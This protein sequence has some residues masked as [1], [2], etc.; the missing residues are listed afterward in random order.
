M[1]NLLVALTASLFS[2]FAAACIATPNEAG[3]VEPDQEM[4]EESSQESVQCPPAGLC[5]SADI[6]CVDLQ[7]TPRACRTLMRCRECE[8][9]V[10]DELGV[11]ETPVES[12]ARAPAA[13]ELSAQALSCPSP[14]TCA[15]AEARC[16]D[17]E[18]TPSWCSI[19]TRCLMCGEGL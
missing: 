12:S 1:K 8:D 14:A 17:P 19:L 7:T 10:E 6:S 15:R 11:P 18:T 13:E 16:Q 3:E 2:S 9:R 5:R 4:T